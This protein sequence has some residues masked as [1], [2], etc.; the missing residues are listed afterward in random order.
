MKRFADG[1]CFIC[2]GTLGKG[3]TPDY[4][5]CR[6]CGH[7]LLK[8]QQGH[9]TIVNESLNFR[10]LTKPSWLGKYKRNFL[11]NRVSTRKY[12]LDIG[13]G[14][15]GFLFQVRRDFEKIQGL[16][17]T[18]ECVEFGNEKLGV[19]LV[20][21]TRDLDSGYSAMT[22][23]HSLEHL[24]CDFLKRKMPG[25]FQK[26]DPDGRVIISVPNEDSLAFKIMGRKFPYYDV[27]NHL[28]Q[29]SLKSLNQYMKQQ[30]FEAEG[31]S[32]SLPYSGFC[33]LQGLLNCFNRRHNYLYYR[34]KRAWTFGLRGK[35]LE[36]LDF[37]NRMLACILAPV[38]VP[39]ILVDALVKRNGAT[40]NACYRRAQ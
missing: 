23:W 33:W 24:S 34:Q 22:M 30:G 3:A 1:S 15:G 10:R 17:I 12:L 18:P 8:D 16:E 2:D 4:F 40:I 11:L 32:F 9:E 28:Q 21:H 26:L 5:K 38:A 31:L 14:S 13:A 7:A 19:H 29:F 20:A 27:S 36:M 39:G 35:K 6:S 25:I 37:Y